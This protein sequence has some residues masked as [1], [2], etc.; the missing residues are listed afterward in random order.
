MLKNGQAY[1]KKFAKFVLQN[2]L[3]YV[4]Q[5]NFQDYIWKD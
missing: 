2:F 3:K 5:D 1:F 4:L